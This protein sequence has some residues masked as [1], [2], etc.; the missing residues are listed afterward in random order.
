MVSFTQLKTKPGGFAPQ[1]ENWPF[2]ACPGWTFQAR[3]WPTSEPK[4]RGMPEGPGRVWAV[5]Q[6]SRLAHAASTCRSPP[7]PQAEE[8]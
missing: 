1:V 6:L 2:W 4:A 8:V 3:E 5:G 7:I